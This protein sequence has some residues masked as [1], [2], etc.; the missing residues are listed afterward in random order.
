MSKRKTKKL[1]PNQQAYAKEVNRLKLAVRRLEKRGY[2]FSDDIIPQMPARVTKTAIQRLQET[3]T[4]HLYA[5]A[6]ALDE[7]TGEIISG[8]E[9]RHIERRESAMK[10]VATR[11][12]K[13]QEEKKKQDHKR[14]K[15]IEPKGQ[16]SKKAKVKTGR[17]R[18][19]D[20]EEKKYYPKGG[21]IIADNVIDNFIARLQEPSP[22]VYQHPSGKTFKRREQ[23]VAES[24]RA[25]HTLLSLTYS[26][27]N[28]IGKEE[29]GWR[30]QEHAEQVGQLV[31]AVLYGSDASVI[32]SACAELASI[33][34][35]GALS[36]EQLSDIAEQEEYNESWG[37][38]LYE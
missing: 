31:D 11:Q 1:T 18:H 8:T 38:E 2:R 37:S 9:K 29:L 13:L 22:T 17:D 12:K 3:T 23:A 21:N 28:D 25:K 20:E 16:R 5:E 4:R 30:L 14:E 7:D 36:L 6:T 26:V 34:N 33:I 32:A 19:D 27:M 35:G 24:E 10:A 15:Q